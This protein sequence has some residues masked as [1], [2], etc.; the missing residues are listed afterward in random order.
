[1]HRALLADTDV[2]HAWNTF[3]VD[4]DLTESG[5]KL[6][7]THEVRPV[8][9][10]SVTLYYPKWIPGEHSASGP[11]ENLVGLKLSAG[12]KPPAWRRDSVDMYAS[13]WRRPR[14]VWRWCSTP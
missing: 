8:K 11:L 10:G 5:R 14:R 13:T 6:L 12:G 4:V 7:Q 1:M 3:K 9:P 2:A